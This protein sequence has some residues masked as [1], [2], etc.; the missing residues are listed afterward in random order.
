MR[1]WVALAAAVL[2]VAI[3]AATTPAAAQVAPPN[4]VRALE[5]QF[6][7]ERGVRFTETMSWSSDGSRQA[8]VQVNGRLQF[9]PSGVVAS[10]G[11]WQLTPAPKSPKDDEL[12]SGGR[13]GFVVAGG[14]V[15]TSNLQKVPQV[16]SRQK[17]PKGGP[18]YS[19]M[20]SSQSI[21][22][23]DPAI[24]KALLKGV[25][26]EPVSGGF[27]YRGAISYEDLYKADKGVYASES[28]P[29]QE[30]RKHKKITW[31]LWTDGTGLPTRLSTVQVRV[32]DKS[33]TT[34]QTDTRYTGWGSHVLIT[35]PP[36]G[37]VTD[38]QDQS[39]PLSDPPA[40]KGS[41]N[42]PATH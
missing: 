34:T 40:P 36:A 31:R 32:S 38:H 5:R 37:Q 41:T 8:K 29:P 11:T 19:L 10:D 33:V 15:Y 26:G 14:S 3:P 22:V 13:V 6:Q 28:L 39:L 30:R 27:L 17:T 23:F 1:R 21:K 16:W 25:T 20:F 35:A 7:P 2:F 42:A 24:L 18:N 4:P 12:L 9:G